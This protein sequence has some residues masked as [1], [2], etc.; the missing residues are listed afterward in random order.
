M[1][2]VDVEELAKKQGLKP[3][4]QLFAEETKWDMPKGGKVINGRYYTQ[5]ALERMAPDTLEIRAKLS[6]RAEKIA[7]QKGYKL[8][9]KDY[10]KFCIKYV[11]NMEMRYLRR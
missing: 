1:A 8:G 2:V 11:Q 7:N 4:L 3:N 10:N 6:R 9:T 5:H